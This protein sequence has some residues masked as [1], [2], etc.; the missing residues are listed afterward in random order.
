MKKVGLIAAVEIEAVTEKYKEP[1][2]HFVKAGCEIYVYYRNDI[3]L[4]VVNCGVG[5]ISAAAATQLL[6]SLYN[7]ETILNF[8]IVGGLTEEMSKVP[9]CIVEK[10]VH[11]QFDTSA[12]DNCEPG[13]YVGEFPDKY[14][15]TTPELIEKALAIKPDLKKVI[16]A[17]GDVFVDTAADKAALHEKF[18]ADIC[19]MEAAAIVKICHRNNVPVLSIKMVSDSLTG[20]AEEYNNNF[21]TASNT[22]FEVMDKVIESL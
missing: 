1:V 20:G 17:S 13:H 18:N 15:P 12:I 22:C 8:G 2:D 9:L 21:S 14:M 16:C 4:Y 10:V 6:I 5:E 3:E 19:E 7:C 11:H